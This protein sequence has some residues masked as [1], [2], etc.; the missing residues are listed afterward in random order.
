[1]NLASRKEAAK[2]AMYAIPNCYRIV[3][4]CRLITIL[5]R[6]SDHILDLSFLHSV[7][8]LSAI[9]NLRLEVVNYAGDTRVLRTPIPIPRCEINIF[10]ARL[11]LTSCN[12]RSGM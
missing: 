3:S 11:L 7:Y 1:M 12:C 6:R 2:L 10:I 5:V 8:S 4:L 9:R